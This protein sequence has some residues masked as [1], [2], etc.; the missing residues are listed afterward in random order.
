MAEA[1]I[2]EVLPDKR[3]HRRSVESERAPALPFTVVPAQP[4]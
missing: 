1:A 2:A 4:H 3:Q